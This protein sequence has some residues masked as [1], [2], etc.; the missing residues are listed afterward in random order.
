[1]KKNSLVALAVASIAFFPSW[2]KS[3]SSEENYPKIELTSF[4]KSEIPKAFYTKEMKSLEKK[5][6]NFLNY[7]IDDFQKDTETRLLAR[8][9]LGEAD[10]C[11][12]TE[13]IA[14]GFT[15]LTRRSWG[16]SL[17]KAILQKEAYSCFN[18]D[19]SRV[20]DLKDPL[21]KD[22]KEFLECL[23]LAEELLNGKYKNP[24][25]GATHYYNPNLVK[26]PDSWKNLKK[27]GRINVEDGKLSYHVY[28]K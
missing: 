6:D 8:L 13:R 24:A 10:I 20:S 4:I 27:I 15:V 12:K 26:K 17:K 2:N 21:K 22:K 11:A 3:Y 1:M 14:I 23:N 19:C 7:R 5:A 18:P 9:L 25:R 28:Y 16:L